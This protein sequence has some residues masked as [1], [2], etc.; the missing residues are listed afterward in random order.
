MGTPALLL[1]PDLLLDGPSRDGRMVQ[2]A[3]GHVVAMNAQATLQ[4]GFA[5]RSR[6]A[7]PCWRWPTPTT[8]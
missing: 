4:L 5:T 7:R 6:T 8:R 2:D 3:G 1:E